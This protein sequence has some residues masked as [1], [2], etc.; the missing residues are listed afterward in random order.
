MVGRV[1][2]THL[3]KKWRDLAPF[4]KYFPRL[5]GFIGPFP[6]TALDELIFTFGKIINLSRRSVKAAKSV[7]FV[8]LKPRFRLI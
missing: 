1:E 3:P 4:G 8:R 6:S 2:E 7:L 5:P